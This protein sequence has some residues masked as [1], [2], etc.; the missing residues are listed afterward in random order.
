MTV[1]SRVHCVR[2]SPDGKRFVGTGN[3]LDAKQSGTI[4]WDAETGQQLWQRQPGN[5]TVYTAEF[6]P[7]GKTLVSGSSKHQAIIWDVESGTKLATLDGHTKA[8]YRIFFS[9]DGSRIFTVSS[10]G[11]LRVW[12]PKCE[13]EMLTIK[14]VYGFAALSPDCRTL[15]TPNS[16]LFME[17]TTVPAMYQ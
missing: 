6:S 4:L 15:V 14:D 8:V 3:S 1:A 2:F 17:V 9:P 16:D 10:D 5:F 7:D 13:G 11:T 12:D